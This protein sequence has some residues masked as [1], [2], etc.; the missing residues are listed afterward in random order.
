MT[1]NT[2]SNVN[3]IVKIKQNDIE[4]TV[5]THAKV[6]LRYIKEDLKKRSDRFNDTRRESTSR[7]TIYTNR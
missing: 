7:N 6:V 1:E 3:G 2:E 4:Y 5:W